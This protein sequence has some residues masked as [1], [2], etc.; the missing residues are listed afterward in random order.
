[1]ET[2]KDKKIN[3][4]T[5]NILVISTTLFRL[6]FKK[7][8]LHFGCV[9]ILGTVYQMCLLDEIKIC[10]KII[11]HHSLSRSFFFKKLKFL[12]SS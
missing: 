10:Y 12:K 9:N 4:K 5:K 1:M 11:L 3:I 8:C 2:K 7:L 6:Q